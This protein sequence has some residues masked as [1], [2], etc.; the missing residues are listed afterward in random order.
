MMFFRRII[1][2]HVLA[3]LTFMLV[4]VLGIIAYS[5]MPRARDPDINFN[6]VTIITVLPG[7]SSIEVEKRITDPLEEAINRNI[8]DIRFASS[9]SRNG[10]S[11]ILLRFNDISDRQFDRRMADL[12]REVQNVY[13]DQLPDEALDPEVLELTSSSGFPTAIVS[14][15]ANSA[16]VEFRRYSDYVRKQLERLKGVDEAQATGLGDPELHIA[17]YPDRLE[18]LGVSPADLT[19]TMRSYFNDVSIGDV[20][21]SNGR[22]QVSLEGTSGSLDKIEQFPIVGTSEV[23]PLGAVADVYYA[24]SEPGLLTRYQGSPAVMFSVTKQEGVNILDILESIND[25]VEAENQRVETKG[26]RL[27][28]VDDQTVA[29]REAISLMVNNALIGLGL[30]TLVAYVF[31]GGRI[32]ALT[33]I[34][35]PF[36]LAGTF[37]VLDTLNMSVNNTVLLGILISLGMLV[38]DA[39]VVV[40][41]IHYRIQ[42]GIDAVTA[43]I[44]SLREVAAPV[45]TSVM[46]TISVFFPLMLLPG[47]LG[48]FMKVIPMVV[49]VALAISLLEAFWMLPAHVTFLKVGFDKGSRTQLIRRRFTRWIRH[50]YSKILITGL[51]RPKL[52]FAAVMAMMIGAYGM[53]FA[54]AVNFNFFAADPLRLVYVNAELPQGAT[55]EQSLDVVSEL[56]QQ[57]LTILKPEE[58]RNSISYSG[59][60]FTAMEPLFGDNLAQ[61]FISIQPG[62]PGMRSVPEMIK[63]VEEG[64][65]DR[66]KDAKVSVM[67]LEDGPPVGKPISAKVRGDQ[68]G[69]IQ[70]VVD[71]LMG[72]LESHGDFNNITTD[73]KPGTPEL[74]LSLN[75]NAIQRAD[76]SP[77]TVT[78]SLQSY[79]DGELV[80]QYQHLGEELDVRL[81]PRHPITQVEEVLQQTLSNR[82]GES[83]TLGTLVDAEYGFGYQNIRHYNFRR[84][85]TVEADIDTE[86][87]DTV[88]ANRLLLDYWDTIKGDYPTIDIDFSGA[89][90]D[91]QESIDGIVA[92]FVMGLGLIYLILGTQFRSY[93]QPIM[94]LVAVPLAI[95]GVIYGLVITNN[96]MSL[97]TMYGVVALSGISVNAAIVL[98]SAANDR[99]E[100]GMSVLHATVFAARRRVVPVLITSF[101]TIAGLFS[102]AAGFA[103]E[104]LLWGP[105]ATAIVSGLMFST[106]LVLIVIPLLYFLASSWSMS[107]RPKPQEPVLPIA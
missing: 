76:L 49:C 70:Q 80:S 45:F 51:R 82:R 55:L 106:V 22:W 2:N 48:E 24:Q 30:V 61:A 18:G 71:K 81:I 3:N 107:H 43:A 53:L 7:A 4:L 1:E 64:L 75:G 99:R 83:V 101:T 72:Y 29:T 15:S 35:I 42:R 37:V 78:R 85:I 41:A 74:K 33:G 23:V 104:S 98:I 95:A 58:V 39:V 87:L 9:T 40:E 17:F 5:S 68:F 88:E 92:L 27:T 14:L 57:T 67:M 32:A 56:E 93:T 20:D 100:Q 52:A 19:D 66:Y 84:A 97:S 94:V 86:K 65:G 38:D 54:G 47:I 16:D 12:R 36:T 28:L 103:G 50:G 90:D 96:P 11:N 34:G 6:W 102:L 105:I 91:I 69:E 73:F 13:T 63:A 77:I 62:Q 8:K 10:L 46:T 31:L 25:F 59:Q 44:E 26:Y 60:M 79:V 21:S 89:L